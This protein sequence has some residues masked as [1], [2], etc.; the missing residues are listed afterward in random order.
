MQGTLLTPDQV[1]VFMREP[2]ASHL[3][4]A[5]DKAW[6]VGQVVVF[7]L[8]SFLIFA[9][10]LPAFAVGLQSTGFCCC[11][12]RVYLAQNGCF[13]LGVSQLTGRQA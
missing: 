10:L 1:K 6:L 13:A 2:L 8:V 4:L 7:M 9:S 5:A 12:L 3:V 11:A